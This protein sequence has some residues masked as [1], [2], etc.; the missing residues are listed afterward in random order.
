AAVL[1]LPPA[2]AT[3]LLR[4]YGWRSRARTKPQDPFQKSQPIHPTSLSLPAESRP[5]S[6]RHR[7][8]LITRNFDPDQIVEV[9]GVLGTTHL[10]THPQRIIIPIIFEN[11]L[12]SFTSRDITGRALAKYMSCPLEDEVVQHKHILYGL[13]QAQGVQTAIIVEGPIDAWRLGPGTVATFGIEYTI[14]QVKLLAER[15]SKLFVLFDNDPQAQ[16]KGEQLALELHSLGK[17]ALLV[18]LP[19]AGSNDPGG[20][21]PEEAQALKKDLLGI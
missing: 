13:D 8:Y 7:D 2:E 10:G 21:S 9:W 16:A 15:F 12:V 5:I 3:K 19:E 20:L 14:S 17:D 6:Q 11:R 1:K 18:E 4:Q